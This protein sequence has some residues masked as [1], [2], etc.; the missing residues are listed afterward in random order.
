LLIVHDAADREIDVGEG[1]ALALA[2]PRAQL[3][4]TRG[5]GHLRILSDSETVRRVVDFVSAE[6][7]QDR[8]NAKPSVATET[9]AGPL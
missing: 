6:R 4:L 2:W 9:A 7:Q 5:L 8:A 1:Q 3:T